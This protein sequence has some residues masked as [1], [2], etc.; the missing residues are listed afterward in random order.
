MGDA[1]S[2]PIL[3]ELYKLY[4]ELPVYRALYD[5]LLQMTRTG[6]IPFSLVVKIIHKYDQVGHPFPFPFLGKKPAL[7]L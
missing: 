5:V 4:R 6:D 1:T 7:L 3:S 2:R